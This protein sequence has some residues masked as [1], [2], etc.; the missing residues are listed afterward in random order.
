M[1]KI[2][3]TTELP[4]KENMTSKK[5]IENVIPNKSDKLWEI[6]II[7]FENI[8]QMQVKFW[9]NK[10]K[11]SS[12]LSIVTKVFLFSILYVIYLNV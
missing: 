8:Y 10:Y 11:I 5:F 1:L 2:V 12:I 9:N 3:S 7:R 6:N 4:I